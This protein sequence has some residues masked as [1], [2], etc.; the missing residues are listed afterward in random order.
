MISI[1]ISAQILIIPIIILHFNTISLTFLLS[2]IIAVP[3]TGAIILYGYSNIFIAIFFIDVAKK[4]GII[5]NFLLKTLIIISK[6]VSKIPLSNIIIPT[7]NIAYIILYY[8]IVINFRNKKYLKFLLIISIVIVMINL[9]YKLRQNNLEIDIIDVGQGD[10]TLII[11]PEGKR[12]LIDGGEKENVLLE[13]LLDKQIIKVDYI[14]ISHFDSDHCYNLLEIIKK[15]RVKNLVI[16]KQTQETELF[17]QIINSCKN[18]KVNIVFVEAGNKINISKDITIKILWPNNELSEGMTINDNSIVA[19]LEYKNFSMLFTG[20]IE[21]KTEK[22]LAELYS[23][24]ILETTVLKIAHHG[25]NSS[26]GKL[27]LDKIK[28]KVAVI[29]VGKDNKFGHPSYNVIE[30]LKLQKISIF[31]TDINGEIT[32][33]VNK[34]GRIKVNCMNM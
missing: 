33:K 22:K 23:G 20:D 11:T 30:R 15:L 1:A 2:N 3:L 6:I 5:L 13:Y 26:T 4:I 9:I 21:Q 7:P 25:S 31:R 10:G 17:K 19:K 34:K 18:R 16:S 29:G 32:I 14:F 28:P 27:I 8:L 24:E 12:I